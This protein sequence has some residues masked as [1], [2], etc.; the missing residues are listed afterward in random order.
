MLSTFEFPLIWQMIRK[1]RGTFDRNSSIP[2]PLQNNAEFGL[3]VV[4][5]HVHQF[6]KKIIRPKK[7]IDNHSSTKVIKRQIVTIPAWVQ[8]PSLYCCSVNLE[9][10]QARRI[11]DWQ[12][13]ETVHHLHFSNYSAPDRGTPYSQEMSSASHLYHFPCLKNNM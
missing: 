2:K 10:V 13:G 5:S 11:L 1:R 7:I 9:A 12:E 6:Q 4:T 8:V 3:H